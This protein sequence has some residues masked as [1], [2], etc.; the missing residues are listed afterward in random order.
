[1]TIFT[2]QISQQVVQDHSS[3][4]TSINIQF[5]HSPQLSISIVY[6]DIK[7]FILFDF[8]RQRNLLVIF[9]FV[10]S[11]SFRLVKRTVLFEIYIDFV[12]FALI[13]LSKQRDSSINYI[14]F[15]DLISTHF[16]R[17]Q[18]SLTTFFQSL[19]NAFYRLFVFTSKTI[20]SFSNLSS[21]HYQSLNFES[22]FES[23]L[24]FA[25]HFLLNSFA[26]KRTRKKTYSKSFIKRKGLRR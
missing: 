15:D 22:T 5:A 16:S 19:Q 9:K 3:V 13:D 1:M 11:V 24:S 8:S 17:L 18:S 2:T 25:Y 23:R 10:D 7:D 26:D 12:D 4:F 21:F 20:I 6:F 14:N